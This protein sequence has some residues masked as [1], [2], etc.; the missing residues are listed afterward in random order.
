[1]IKYPETEQFRNVKR[2]V[3]MKAQHIG[4]DANGDPIMD[5]SVKLPTLCL[6]GT[7]K[8]HGT[9]SAVKI[10]NKLTN[11]TVAEPA[12]P[13]I[14]TCQSRER[15]ITPED[16]NA[17]FARF[18]NNL[19]PS[20]LTTFIDLFG[21]NIVVYGEWAGKGIQPN[22]AVSQLDK[23]WTVFA[24]RKIEDTEEKET[25]L[26][27]SMKDLTM[28]NECRIYSIYQFGSFHTTM[29]FENPG[30]DVNNI[31]EL[32]MK[33]ESECPVG[34]FF[35]IS[36]GVGE[37]IVWRITDPGY[38]NS[39]FVF[40]TKG[41]K[42]SESKVTKLATVDVEKMNNINE[43][44]DKHVHEGRLNQGWNWLAEM[45]KPQEVKSTG[46][47]IK[48]VTVDVLKEE[49]DEL[50]ASGLT[51]KELNGAVSTKARRWFMGKLGK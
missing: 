39:K 21:D 36:G 8:I 3:E 50:V 5:R 17:G 13:S 7:V 51:E 30:V 6:E 11:D 47:F 28:L 12:R 35:G 22:V 18:I 10:T 4:V 19:S 33:V 38:D 41:S 25:W 26:N 45:K 34:K 32:T 23:F 43:F 48:W 2:Q 16:D 49:K 24:V 20:I 37:G 27:L 46:D 40:K 9:N 29:D 15:E 14:I 42:H 31:N 44:V 1:M